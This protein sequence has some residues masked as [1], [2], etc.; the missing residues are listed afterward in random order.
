M[1]HYYGESKAQRM[2]NDFPRILS[3]KEVQAFIANKEVVY[4]S[5]LSKKNN[6]DVYKF[7][8]GRLIFKRAD[9]KGAYWKSIE[10]IEEVMSKT[11]HKIEVLNL[12]NWITSK[13]N[14]A[15]IKERSLQILESKTGQKLD[16]SI[17][18][19]NTVNKLKITD[20]V[21]QK[22]LFYSIIYYSCEVCAKTLN[23]VIDIELIS[24]TSFYR[25]ITKDDKNRIYIPY[26]EY[27]KSFT[28]KKKMAISQSVD[29]ELSK[30]KF[31][32]QE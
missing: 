24:G 7:P 30:Y 12:T 21:K 19:L 9:G 16:Y 27:L 32:Q 28:G 11:D 15:A 10:Q 22:E 26:A 18:S 31:F 6:L 17:N 13:E 2:K 25:P 8:D 23:G 4:D 29:V 14:L 3:K 20:I 5:V 1:L